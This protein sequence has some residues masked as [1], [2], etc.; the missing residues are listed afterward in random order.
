MFHTMLVCS[1][2]SEQQ[3]LRQRRRVTRYHLLGVLAGMC[4]NQALLCRHFLPSSLRRRRMDQTKPSHLLQDLLTN[5]RL[6]V[7][8]KHF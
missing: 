2:G 8:R 1:D 7:L 5:N 6:R 3:Y 4:A